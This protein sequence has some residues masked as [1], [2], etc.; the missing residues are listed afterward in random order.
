MYLTIGFWCLALMAV[1]EV[2]PRTSS[3]LDKHSSTDL[4]PQPS[5]FCFLCCGEDNSMALYSACFITE[6]QTQPLAIFTLF[7][8]V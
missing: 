8:Y 6:L 5:F 2:E 7:G 1:V 4:Q 3:M